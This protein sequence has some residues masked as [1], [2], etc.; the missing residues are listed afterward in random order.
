MPERTTSMSGLQ[1]KIL[2]SADGSPGARFVAF[3]CLTLSLTPNDDI[4]NKSIPITD[5]E[6][7]IIAYFL[8]PA[9]FLSMKLMIIGSTTVTAEPTPPTVLP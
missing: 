7:A 1:W 8:S 3:G 9:M 2:E 6:I 5:I 4:Q